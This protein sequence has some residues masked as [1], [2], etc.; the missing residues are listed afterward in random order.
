MRDKL[1]EYA[2]E[3]AEWPLAAC[4]LDPVRASVVCRG[5]AQAL[6]KLINYIIIY[7][8]YYYPARR[9]RRHQNAAAVDGLDD[10][11][12]NQVA[13]RR[14]RQHDAIAMMAFRRRRREVENVQSKKLT[15]TV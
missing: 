3:G 6:K 13:L 11:A 10:T 4:I 5:P 7:Y 1:R 8:Y 9:H 15:W 14:S 12:H 2:A